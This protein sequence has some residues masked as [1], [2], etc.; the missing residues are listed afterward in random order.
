[1][2]KTIK[3][4]FYVGSNNK[5]HKT[6]PLKAVEVLKH[7]KIKGYTLKN[8]LSGFWDNTKEKSF[9]IEVI[10]TQDNPIN[11]VTALNIKEQLKTDL[12]QIEVL[13]EKQ[14]TILI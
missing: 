10:K 14:D 3:Y 1:M 4:L 8:G 13:T 7:N 9:I 2:I 12:N 6:E 5:T 11:D